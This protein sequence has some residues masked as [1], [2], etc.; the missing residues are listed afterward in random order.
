[1]PWTNDL[2]KT[3]W[4]ELLIATQS[5]KSYVIFQKKKKS[6]EKRELA[7]TKKL[8]DKLKHKVIETVQI[9]E[10]LLKCLKKLENLIGVCVL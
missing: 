2:T 9:A 10:T 6:F 4:I 7:R 8:N 3:K 5:T 1:M